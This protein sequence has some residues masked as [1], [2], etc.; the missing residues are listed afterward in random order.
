LLSPLSD[1]P[2]SPT[3][4]NSYQVG[5][6]NQFEEVVENCNPFLGFLKN[7]IQPYIDSS[8]YFLYGWT[9]H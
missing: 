6:Q 5:F 3:A 9:L 4:K 1:K 8:Q 2:D 7:Y